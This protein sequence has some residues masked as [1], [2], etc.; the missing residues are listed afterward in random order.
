MLTNTFIYIIGSD[1]LVQRFWTN[2]SVISAELTLHESSYK[3]EE[4]HWPKR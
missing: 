3:E 2:T 4:V 1:Y